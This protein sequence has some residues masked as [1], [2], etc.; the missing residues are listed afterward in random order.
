MLAPREECPIMTT[1]LSQRAKRL[2]AGLCPECGAEQRGSLTKLGEL[3][4]KRKNE[5][6]RKSRAKRSLPGT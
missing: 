6:S 4:R 5:A 3:C 1:E 2:E